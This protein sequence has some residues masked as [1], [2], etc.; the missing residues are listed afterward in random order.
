[1]NL[2]RPALILLLLLALMIVAFW[3][4]APKTA[5][6]LASL[7][8][9]ILVS[10]YALYSHRHDVLAASAAFFA[11]VDINYYLF[12][13]LSPIW[14]GLIILS[15]VLL[16]I[17]V[18]L[19][20]QAQLIVAIGSILVTLELMLASQYINLEPKVQALFIILPFI[21]GSQWVYFQL[22]PPD[23]RAPS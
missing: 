9:F 5:E 14:L 2:K 17:W 4:L 22:H 3:L 7:L 8:F 15:L 20:G 23:N 11:A 16:I 1:M 18:V 19:F 6:R 12:D 21:I 13:W 10:G